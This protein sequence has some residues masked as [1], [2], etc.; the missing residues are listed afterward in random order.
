MKINKLIAWLESKQKSK[1]KTN[2]DKMINAL[3]MLDNPQYNYKTVHITGTNGKGST[4]KF[5]SEILSQRYKVGLFT[6]PYIVKF[7]ERIQVNNI[8]VEDSVLEEYIS[9][10]Q[11][12]EKEFETKYNDTFSYFELLTIIS[13]KYFSDIKVDYAVIEVGIGGLLDSTNVLK[14]DLCIITSVGLDHKE[15]L[16]D[17]IEDILYQKTGI[18]K[19]GGLLLTGLKNYKETIDKYALKFGGNVKYID[20]NDYELVDYI[21][22]KIMYKNNLYTSNLLGLYQINNLITA[23]EAINIL[24][25][26]F[27]SELIAI[28]AIKATNPGRFELVKNEPS[29]ILDGGHNL[30][31]IKAL[32]KSVKE[33]FENK[34]TYILFTSFKDK[35]FD[36]MLNELSNYTNNIYLTS[37]NFPRA[38]T[39]FTGLEVRYEVIIDPVD[40]YKHILS[41]ADNEDLIVVTGSMYLVSEI[42]KYIKENN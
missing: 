23:I 14:S 20:Y 17:T 30:E 40:A 10:A 32:L 22:L 26:S 42:R 11:E 1:P 27:T 21:P 29:V 19:S 4:S 25:P 13:F 34:K 9:W 8:P 35:P 28:G 12:F 24:E 41:I 39:D 31:A 36:E 33:M 5:I 37:L 3:D 2:L 16:G 7:N 6:S 38:K 15:Q 18:L